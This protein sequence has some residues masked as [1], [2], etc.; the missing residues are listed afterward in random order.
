M[1]ILSSLFAAVSG[2]NAT[3]SSISI[4]GDNIANTNTVGYKSARPEFVDVLSGNLSGGGSAGQIGAGSRLSGIT[5]TFTQGSLESTD[6]TTDVAV[7][8]AG[9]FIVQDTTGVFYTRAGLFRLDADQILVNPQ[10]QTVQGFG[11]TATGAPNGALANID[12]STVSSTPQAT[13]TVEVNVNLDP[14]QNILAAFDQANPVTT[15]N[16]QTGIRVYD[17][18]GNPRNILLYLRKAGTLAADV[19]VVGLP[20]RT[21]WEYYAG[22]AKS[23]L[24]P[25]VTPAAA[26]PEDFVAQDWGLLEFDAFGS[27]VR[28]LSGDLFT[29]GNADGAA[30]VFDYDGAGGGVPP[31]FNFNNGAA[32]SQAIALDMGSAQFTAAGASTGNDGFDKTTQFGGQAASGVNNF[33][34]FMN[35]NGFSAGSLQSLQIDEDGFVTGLF[36][37]GTAQRLA[38]IALASFPNAQGLTRVGDNNWAETTASGSRVVGSPNQGGFGVVRS[39]FLELSNVDLADEFVKLILAQR[40]FQANTRTVS[41][42]NELLAN[43]VVLG[44]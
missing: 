39:G 29:D 9:F 35:Q 6:V 10:G 18:L 11:V 24:D 42:T 2:L 30:D 28:Q 3:G 26:A 32:P 17:S 19:P 13:A 27:L 44:Q 22:A 36:S 34:R 33:V 20:D 14:N 43:L 21:I 25:S 41:T 4:I 7:D 1:G 31:N 23:D 40:A 12:L 8:G 15:S 16:F 38:Q 37:N 5:Q